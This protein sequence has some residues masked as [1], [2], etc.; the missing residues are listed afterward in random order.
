MFVWLGCQFTTNLDAEFEPKEKSEGLA[1]YRVKGDFFSDLEATKI[2][3]G[4]PANPSHYSKH[5]FNLKVIAKA[6]NIVKLEAYERAILGY[7]E[8]KAFGIALQSNLESLV[9]NYT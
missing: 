6:G 7:F 8:V 4:K 3:F 5:G 2:V 9:E 1:L